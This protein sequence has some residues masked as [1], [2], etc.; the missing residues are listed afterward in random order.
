MLHSTDE[1]NYLKELENETRPKQIKFDCLNGDAT[2]EIDM[3]SVHSDNE[4]PRG[5]F[6][7]Y[8]DIGLVHGETV[9]KV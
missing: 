3:E 2:K 8:V 5:T 9:S 4:W 7:I 6:T 1:D